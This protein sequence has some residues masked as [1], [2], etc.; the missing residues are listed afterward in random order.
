M[1]AVQADNAQSVDPSPLGFSAQA[2]G[3][4]KTAVVVIH[5]IHPTARFEIQDLFGTQ[6]LRRLNQRDGEGAWNLNL[7]WPR[8]AKAD[9]G[10]SDLHATALRICR[11]TNTD[12]P[13][14]PYF[15][16]FEA[17]WS[18][19]DK[20]QTTLAK[21]L[22]WLSDAI[23]VPLNAG[24]KLCASTTKVLFDIVSVVAVLALSLV[25]LAL[26]AY[27]G[28]Q[29]YGIFAGA[30]TCA[31]DKPPPNCATAYPSP[32]DFV[33][34]P[35]TTLQQ[36]AWPA[37]L[38]IVIAFVGAYALTQLVISI[39]HTVAEWYRRTRVRRCGRDAFLEPRSL[40]RV[41]FQA[42]LAVLAAFGIWWWPWYRPFVADPMHHLMLATLTVVGVV[43][44]FRSAFGMLNEFFV[45]TLGDVQ[46]YTTHDENSA[47][48]KF[49]KEIV[50]LVEG[51]ILQVL[52]AEAGPLV[53][54]PVPR[55]D[56]L[57]FVDPPKPPPLYDRVVIA[58]HSLGSTIG[59]DAL[60]NVHE[61]Y[62]EGGLDF[63]QWS[64]VGAFV[65]FGSSL[66]KT[67]FFFDVKQPTISASPDHWRSDVYGRL[68]TKTFA[69]L[70]Q[71][72][73]ATSQIFWANQW[74]AHD[75]VAN[76]IESYT[77]PGDRTICENTLLPDRFSLVHPWIHSDY[78]WD[79]NF[80]L[81]RP[82]ASTHGMLD[83]LFPDMPKHR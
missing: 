54:M 5:G 14:P 77:A 78:L 74:Y 16:V 73:P 50:E 71:S 34:H 68:F 37:A 19:I 51:V 33:L 64:R 76:R 24:A 83:V 56:E 81:G 70:S 57:R 43:G 11:G 35:T 20:N 31:L 75:I 13:D 39:Y 47:F 27:F 46:I 66:E 38:Y 67:K 44:L 60:L 28:L 15:D 8:I 53:T 26:A 3:R 40:W 79:E 69:T 22:S 18:P 52:R 29:G 17:Y 72:A 30:A 62:E 59:M 63:D 61:L 49:R 58:G 45:N 1:P 36:F 12:D 7:L 21:V 4:G 25:L 65:T 82:G 41:W 32:L 80:W 10:P 55:A 48:Y 6:L 23:F 42:F 9:A 2:G